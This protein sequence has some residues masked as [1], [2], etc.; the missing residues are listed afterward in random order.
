MTT[1]TNR[2]IWWLPMLIM[3]GAM[4]MASGCS[5]TAANQNHAAWDQITASHSVA[6]VSNL[7]SLEQPA[8]Y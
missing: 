2:I 8:F 7:K 4:L 5:N 1:Y 3:L 6:K